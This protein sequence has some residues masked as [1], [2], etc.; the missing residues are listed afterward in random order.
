MGPWF[1]SD[2]NGVLHCPKGFHSHCGLPNPNGMSQKG[3]RLGPSPRQFWQNSHPLDR[4][5]KPNKSMLCD[6]VPDLRTTSTKIKS[7]GV[8]IAN[9]VKAT[10]KNQSCNQSTLIQREGILSAEKKGKN[11]LQTIQDNRN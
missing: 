11:K 10:A 6:A 9:A 5:Y 1:V 3:M 2:V 7:K 4:A 8:I